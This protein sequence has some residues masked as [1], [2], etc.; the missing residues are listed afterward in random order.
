MPETSPLRLDDTLRPH[1]AVQQLEV[2]D[3][4]RVCELFEAAAEASMNAKHRQG[5]TAVLPDQGRLIISG[6]LHDHHDHFHRLIMLAGLADNPDRHLV[7]QEVIHGPKLINKVD[8]SICTLVRVA[9]LKLRFPDQVHVILGNH[10]LAQMLDEGIMKDGVSVVEVFDD[11]L[12]YIFGNEAERVFEAMGTF[13]RSLL[14]AVRCPKQELML[15]HSLPSPMKF[16][17]FDPKVIYRQPTDEDYHPAGSA[18]LLVWGRH[19]TQA[20]VDQLCETWGVKQFVLGHQPAD[21]GWEQKLPNLLVINSDHGHG[22]ALPIDLDKE[23]DMDEM[24]NSV[25]P[26]AAIPLL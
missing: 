18:N 26:L 19:H 20:V 15:C 3:A 5:S 25:V 7:L 2:K 11:G 24:V 10:E 22:M 6:D 23:Y 21:M 9:A 14:L 1:Q 16:A 17:S 12:I 4:D 8:L 13:I